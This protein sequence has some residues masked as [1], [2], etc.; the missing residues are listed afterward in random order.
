MVSVREA[1]LQNGPERSVGCHLPNSLPEPVWKAAL[2]TGQVLSMKEL[3]EMPVGSV[4]KTCAF[5]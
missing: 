1:A 4:E 2:V 5:G 3:A